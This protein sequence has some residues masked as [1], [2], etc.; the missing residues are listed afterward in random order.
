MKQFNEDYIRE[1]VMLDEGLFSKFW[2]WLFGKSDEKYNYWEEDSYD[3]KSFNDIVS[4]ISED[5]VIFK[6]TT[7]KD[8]KKTVTSTKDSVKNKSIF[9]QTDAL[10]KKWEGNEKLNDNI[11]KYKWMT[12]IIDKKDEKFMQIL[13][14]IAYEENFTYEDGQYTYIASCEFVPKFKSALKY[15]MVF[16]DVLKKFNADLKNN[17]FII[18]NTDISLMK[19]LDGY[20]DSFE[21]LNGDTLISKNRYKVIL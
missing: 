19:D 13:G 9:P 16:L 2:D 8:I 11:T 7:F 18:D 6:Q 12:C 5:D 20:I 17:Q 15:N 1:Q 21:K 14:I 3:K 4:T 10:I